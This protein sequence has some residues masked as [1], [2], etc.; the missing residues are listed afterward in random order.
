MDFM[1]TFGGHEDYMNHTG[2]IGHRGENP[3]APGFTD[4]NN[5]P[6]FGH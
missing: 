4:G 1:R 6:M 3:M 2:M 5:T